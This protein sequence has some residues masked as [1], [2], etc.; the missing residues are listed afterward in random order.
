MSYQPHDLQGRKRVGGRKRGEGGEIKG[1]MCNTGRRLLASSSLSSLAIT[2][3]TEKGMKAREG[4]KARR[5]EGKER[6][7][8]GRGRSGEE[9]RQEGKR[10]REGRREE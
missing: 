2:F 9:S 1:K 6:E 3:I 7:R 10:L 4:W 5:G 8:N